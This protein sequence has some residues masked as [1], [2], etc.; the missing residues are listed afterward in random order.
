MAANV[1]L[2]IVVEMVCCLC[3]TFFAG[4]LA[5]F[6]AAFLRIPYLMT[7]TGLLAIPSMMGVGYFAGRWIARRRPPPATPEI[8]VGCVVYTSA[9]TVLVALAHPAV[10]AVS[11]IASA[12]TSLVLYRSAAEHAGLGAAVTAK[13]A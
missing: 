3:G 11:L 13:D 10:A 9:S 4:A 5:G 2:V 12:A 8:I 7:L 6:A 1:A